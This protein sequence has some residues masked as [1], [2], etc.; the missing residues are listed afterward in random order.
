MSEQNSS[1]PAESN[2][3]SNRAV[4]IV[5]LV[6]GLILGGWLGW[7][8]TQANSYVTKKDEVRKLVKSLGGTVKKIG[9]SGEPSPDSNRVVRELGAGENQEVLWRVDLTGS[10]A[11]TDDLKSICESDWI[12]SL[13]LSG[14]QIDDS[15]I[16]EI[17]KLEKLRELS[18]TETAVTDAGIEKLSALKRLIKLDTSG[19][20]VTYAGLA[21]LDQALEGSNFEEQLAMKRRQNDGQILVDVASTEFDEKQVDEKNLLLDPPNRATRIQ[22]SMKDQLTADEIEPIAH[23]TGATYFF[24]AGTN[25]PNGLGFVSNL[26]SVEDFSSIGGN[27][28]DGDVSH[29][30]KLPNLKRVTLLGDF[31]DDGLAVLKNAQNLEFARLSGAKI[32]PAALAHFK[33]LPKLRELDLAF[34]ADPSN[35]TDRAQPTKE[36]IEQTKGELSALESIPNLKRVKIWGTLVVNESLSPLGKLKGLQELELDKRTISQEARDRLA[37]EMPNCEITLTEPKP[38]R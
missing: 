31:S 32:T 17:V 14:K 2:S 28:T 29:V 19:S 11:T 36:T 1:G 34:A 9:L 33:G 3:S 13:K 24:A 21:K 37:Q 27:A 30:A 12:R 10:K 6:I 20:A 26:R 8:Y 7:A 23:L 38:D 18:L 5:V 25:F 22:I 16:D 4:I 15:T 35:S